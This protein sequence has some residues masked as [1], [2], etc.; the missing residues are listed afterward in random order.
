MTDKD[1]NDIQKVLKRDLEWKAGSMKEHDKEDIVQ[2]TLFMAVERYQAGKYANPSEL[3]S[4]CRGQLS[5]FLKPTKKRQTT[6]TMIT[7]KAFYYALD[8]EY[9]HV[10]V[11]YEDS[12]F[13]SEGISNLSDRDKIIIPS[14]QR[15][16]SP[17]ILIE[18]GV[19]KS[20][21]DYYHWRSYFAN[22]SDIQPFFTLDEKRKQTIAMDTDKEIVQSDVR[23]SLHPRR[24]PPSTNSGKPSKMPSL[25]TN[26]ALTPIHGEKQPTDGPKNGENKQ[27]LSIPWICKVLPDLEAVQYLLSVNG[28]CTSLTDVGLYIVVHDIGCCARTS[29]QLLFDRHRYGKFRWKCYDCKET[30]HERWPNTLEGFLM[31][32]FGT[33]ED[34]KKV[35]GDFS[36]D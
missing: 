12:H 22:R 3:L 18:R 17:P 33:L 36:R 31:S 20:K 30:A 1:W 25:N 13:I 21:R 24:I 15:G 35:I 34:V 27:K 14:L 28:I 16:L 23:E 32:I 4:Y 9:P 6:N 10:D 2:E 29:T 7:G 26:F 8:D 19:F 5:N 11:P